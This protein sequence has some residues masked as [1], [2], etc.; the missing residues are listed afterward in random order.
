MSQIAKEKGKKQQNKYA[1]KFL[2]KMDQNDLDDEEDDNCNLNN[3]VITKIKSNLT[4]FSNTSNNFHT[5]VKFNSLYSTKNSGIN[6]NLSSN[7]NSKLNSAKKQPI[8]FGFINKKSNV[9]ASA[10]QSA[11]TSFIHTEEDLNSSKSHKKNPLCTENNFNNTCKDNWN[12]SV[13]LIKTEGAVIN[14]F[15]NKN[16]TPFDQKKGVI[17][18]PSINLQ[19]EKYIDINLN[20]SVNKTP[21][22]TKSNFFNETNKTAGNSPNRYINFQLNGTVDDLDQIS[23]TVRKRQNVVRN[24]SIFNETTKSGIFSCVEINKN[25]LLKNNPSINYKNLSKAFDCADLLSMNKKK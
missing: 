18:Y 9:S 14:D 13:D 11:K 1:K 22:K 25:V 4:N 10:F 19:A 17:K 8:P 16:S 21:R 2:S 6:S 7:I 24:K 15:K 23:N 3:G 5:G 12:D 20:D